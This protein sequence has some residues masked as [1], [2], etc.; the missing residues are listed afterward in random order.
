MR[1][2]VCGGR[3]YF[4]RDFVAKTLDGHLRHFGV[5]L[6]IHGGQSGADTCA[7]WWARQRDI[8]CLRVPAQWSQLGRKAGPIRNGLMLMLGGPTLVLAFPGGLG[9]KNMTDQAIAA[10]VRVEWA[11]DENWEPARG[12]VSRLDDELPE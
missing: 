1:I 7:E 4:K 10:G 6:I 2:L 8:L 3:N 11:P 5:E 9:T 12:E